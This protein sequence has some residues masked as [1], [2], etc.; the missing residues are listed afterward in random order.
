MDPAMDMPGED[1]NEANKIKSEGL[2][3]VFNQNRDN[4]P[5][6]PCPY[7]DDGNPEMYSKENIAKRNELR[8]S[9][10]VNSAIDEFISGVFMLTSGGNCSK[11][12]YF[13]QFMKIGTILRPGIEAD[14]LNRFIKE[15]FE[16]DSQDKAPDFREIEDPGKREAAIKEHEAKPQQTFDYLTKEKLWDALFT[17]AD[18]WCPSIDEYEYQE[19]FSLIKYRLKYYGMQDNDAYDVLT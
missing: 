13:K 14:D 7:V 9:M 2:Q 15:D 19:F 5:N 10:V 18:A 3:F 1:P 17:L 6:N 11:E 16:T 12:E 8:K 4:F